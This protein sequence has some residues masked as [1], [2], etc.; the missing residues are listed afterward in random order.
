MDTVHETR[1]GRRETSFGQVSLEFMVIIGFII[2][3]FIPL[4]FFIYYKTSELNNGIEGL[5]SRLVSSKLAFISNSLGFLGDRNSLKVEITLP[6]MVRSLEFN[7]LGEGGEVLI[8]MKDGTQIS[9]VTSFPFAGTGSYAGGAVY[10]LE[11]ISQNGTI[12]VLPSS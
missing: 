3:L 12:Y 5:E 6:E 8:T 10:K 7:T 4:V 11:F 9:Q 1:N 2:M